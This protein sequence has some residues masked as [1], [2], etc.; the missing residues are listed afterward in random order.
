MTKL[1]KWKKMGLATYTDEQAP[2]A[3]KNGTIVE[4][5]GFQEGDAHEPGMRATVLGSFGPFKFENVNYMYFVEWD[6]MKGVPVSI[7]DDRIREIKC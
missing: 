1:P 6:D 5:R 3:L 2:G 4:K 7:T